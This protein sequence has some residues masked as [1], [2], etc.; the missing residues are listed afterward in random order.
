MVNC[1]LTRSLDKFLSQY[2][3]QQ[4]NITAMNTIQ[5]GMENVK[6]ELNI[7]SNVVCIIFKKP[8]QE[9]ETKRKSK[10]YNQKKKINLFL[11]DQ[12]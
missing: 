2:R 3:R 9:F 10:N 1:N 4:A 11:L 5:A 8:T 12:Y 7:S 6:L